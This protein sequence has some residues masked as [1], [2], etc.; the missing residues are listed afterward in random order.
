MIQEY[1]DWI[2]REYEANGGGVLVDDD[3]MAH[4]EERLNWLE[5]EMVPVEWDESD[6]ANWNFTDRLSDFYESDV[7]EDEFVQELES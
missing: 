5:A 3:F 4:R 2:R 1:Q 6:L 7:D